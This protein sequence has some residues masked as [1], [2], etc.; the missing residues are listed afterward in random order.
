[1]NSLFFLI[2]IALFF[3]TVAIALWL[4]AVNS[5]QYDDLDKE[6]YSIF[7]DDENDHKKINDDTD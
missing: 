2:P 4:W 5:G 6:A 3:S 1:M 7:M